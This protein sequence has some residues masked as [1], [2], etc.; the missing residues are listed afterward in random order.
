MQ[1]IM[2][3]RKTFSWPKIIE[4]PT[5]IQNSAGARSRNCCSGHQIVAQVIIFGKLIF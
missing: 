3:S 5:K 4:R 2:N 1:K